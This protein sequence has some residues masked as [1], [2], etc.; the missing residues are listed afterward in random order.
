[1]KVSNKQLAA[2]MQVRR[3]PQ[4][5]RTQQTTSRGSSVIRTYVKQVRKVI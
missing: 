2:L 5:K 4:S 3:L 1:M